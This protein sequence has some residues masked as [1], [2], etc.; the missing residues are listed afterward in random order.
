MLF[1]IVWSWPHSFNVPG[2]RPE[3]SLRGSISFHFFFQRNSTPA[4]LAFF[5]QLKEKTS[6]RHYIHD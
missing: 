5:L 1:L 3:A 2:Y 4:R 6:P